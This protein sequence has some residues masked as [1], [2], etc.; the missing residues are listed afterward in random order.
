[1]SFD[2]T[3]EAYIKQNA[4]HKELKLKLDM[5]KQGIKNHYQGQEER[6]LKINGVVARTKT[7]KEIELKDDIKE[8]LKDYGYLP[9]VVKIN[10]SIENHFNLDKAKI[11]HK[12]SVRLYTGGKSLIDKESLTSKYEHYL[13]SGLDELTEEF[14][15]ASTEEKLAETKLNELKE[16][17]QRAMPSTSVP[18]NFGTLKITDSYDYDMNIVFDGI[19]GKKEI[20]IKKDENEDLFEVVIYPDDQTFKLPG[21]Q[22]LGTVTIPEEFT[23][24]NN[25][26]EVKY[27]KVPV[28]VEDLYVT[29]E[30]EFSSK[31]ITKRPFNKFIKE[32]YVFNRFEIDVDPFEFFEQ[33]E[34]SKTKIDDLIQQGIIDEKDIKPFIELVGETDIVEVM[35]EGSA[36]QQ[37]SIYHK[38]LMEKAQNYRKRNDNNYEEE[39]PLSNSQTPKVDFSDFSF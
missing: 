15:R 6:L 27:E 34:V 32:G 38:K 17:L 35:S 4:V 31:F 30:N 11:N 20:F 19:S 10:K 14:K 37:A 22:E 5:I 2:K 33:C 1:M 8:F 3:F 25:E 24:E 9:L 26:V 18:T 21:E 7:R 29:S 36:E 12:Q 28:T 23:N 13:E 16:E 39:Q